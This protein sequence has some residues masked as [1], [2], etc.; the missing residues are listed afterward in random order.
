M[1]LYNSLLNG[2][3][4]REIRGGELLKICE[5]LEKNPMD[6]ADIPDK[7]EVEQEVIISDKEYKEIQ[8]ITNDGELVASITDEDVIE[9]DGYKV[10]CV[11][12]EN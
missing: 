1:A 7:E 6:F 5:F 9:R 12:A 8:I 3:R 4:D 10:V 2:E 11:P